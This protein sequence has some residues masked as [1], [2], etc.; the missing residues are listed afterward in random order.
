MTKQEFLEKAKSIH[1]DK[2]EYIELN[3]KILSTDNIQ[4]MFDGEI[5]TQRVVKHLIGRCPEKNTPKKT[6]EQFIK[7]SMLVW[8]DKYDY[9]KTIYTGAFKDV[10]IIYNGLEYTQSPISHLRGN[11]PEFRLSKE[12]FIKRSK[13]KYEDDYDYSLVHDFTN[14]DEKV[15]IIHKESGKVYEQSPYNHSEHRPENI[16]LAERKTTKTFI[17]DARKIHGDKFDYSKVDY[18]TNHDKVIIICSVHG[19]IEQTPM[20]HLQGN[21][22][23]LCGYISMSKKLKESKIRYHHLR[24][25]KVKYTTEEYIALAKAKHGDKYDYSRTVFVNTSTPVDIIYDGIIYQI[26]PIGHLTYPLELSL[27]KDNFI[28]RAI[29]KHKDKYDYSLVDFVNG[30]T[31][32]KIIHKETGIVYEQTPHNHLKYSPENLNLVSYEDF[33]KRST[34]IHFN[35]YNYDKSVY[36]NCKT[37]ITITCP[38]HGD[39]EQTPGSHMSGSG[40]PICNESKGEKIIRNYLS[41]NEIDFISQ[42]TFPDCKYVSLLKFDFYLPDY[43]LCIEFDGI[44]HFE[45]SDFYG[46]EEALRKTQERDKVK[47]EYCIQN[48]IK[49]LRI[50][51]DELDEI[52]NILESV[53]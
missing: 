34:E 49:M 40:C 20:S 27:S 51:Y 15:K 5:Y 36:I 53:L 42:K 4:M 14:G 18:K 13:E 9:S 47:D 52:I 2:Y 1:K 11:S 37:K 10:I 16:K 38:K 19:E 35:K 45:A 8:G 26:L 31:K 23:R 30:N 33:I 29:N 7:E 12:S 22:C 48:D 24:K 43:N 6:T 50:K 17:E 39:F 46:G 32:V 41:I 44:Q 3:D 28:D 25:Y 21:G